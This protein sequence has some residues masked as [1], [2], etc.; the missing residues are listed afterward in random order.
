MNFTD[1]SIIEQTKSLARRAEQVL[2]LADTNGQ[3]PEVAAAL[4]ALGKEIGAT[5][6][7]LSTV[8]QATAILDGVL[9]SLCE[10]A[11]SMQD[12]LDISEDGLQQAF[13]WQA[14]PLEVWDDCPLV[15]LDFDDD[16]LEQFWWSLV[17]AVDA[18]AA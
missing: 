9:K 12:A 14:A 3:S 13:A 8:T 1:Q 7:N 16:E 6:T 17:E 11:E 18:E 15:A 4:L 2:A 5:Q 10:R